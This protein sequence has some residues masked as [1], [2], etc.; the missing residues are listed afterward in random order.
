MMR[1]FKKMLLLMASLLVPVFLVACGDTPSDVG[2]ASGGRYIEGSVYPESRWTALQGGFYLHVRLVPVAVEATLLDDNLDSIGTVDVEVRR[3][4]DGG[5]SFASDSL[6]FASSLLR[7]KFTCIYADSSSG[8]A[9]DF[10]QY[11]DLDKDSVIVLSL[12]AYRIP[13][14]GGRVR[15]RGR[16][17]QS[18]TRN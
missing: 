16:E 9:M 18:E 8:L 6:E 5:S 10:V 7:V 2:L 12:A 3:H 13:G 15:S 4:R 11:V 1:N 14:A 17:A